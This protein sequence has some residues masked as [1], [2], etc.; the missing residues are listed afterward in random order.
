MTFDQKEGEKCT[1]SFKKAFKF[2]ND[3]SIKVKFKY[4]P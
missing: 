3:K 2:V 4:C 1:A